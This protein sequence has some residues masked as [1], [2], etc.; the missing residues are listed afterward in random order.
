[1]YKIDSSNRQRERTI[2]L[3]TARKPTRKLTKKKEIRWPIQ[4][5]LKQHFKN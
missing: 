4:H 3:E 5:R 1:M 2:A